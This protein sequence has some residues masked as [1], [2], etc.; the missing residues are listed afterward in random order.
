MTEPTI[1]IGD[2]DWNKIAE[3][4]EVEGVANDPVVE[5]PDGREF[6]DPT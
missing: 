5:Y 1:D 3:E 4:W 2:D 6:S